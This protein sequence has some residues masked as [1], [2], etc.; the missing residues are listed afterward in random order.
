MTAR[1]E[2][3]R[4][5]LRHMSQQVGPAPTLLGV[6]SA[7][8]ASK[9][10]CQIND[11]GV[12][13]TGVRLQAVLTGAKSQNILPTIGAQA[14]AVRIEQSQDWYLLA[15]SSLDEIQ[16]VTGSVVTEQSDD[17]LLIAKGSDTLLDALIAL[18][19][20]VEKIVVLQGTNPDYVKIA[21]AKLKINNILKNAT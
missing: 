21:Q 7:V 6:V 1:A 3:I 11:D 5:Q 15:S 14:L 9:G 10:T 13:Y 17:G 2:Q 20:G 16:Q 4:Q 19:E 12:L 8:D 18:V